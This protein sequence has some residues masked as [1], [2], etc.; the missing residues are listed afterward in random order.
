MN[1]EVLYIDNE[2]DIT[3]VINKVK[4][5]KEKIVALVPPKN[6]GV[7]RS[8]VNLRL[9]ARTADQA[10][11]RVV[12]ISNNTALKTMAA[13]AKI[14]V[15]KTLQSKPEIPEI[16]ALEID[17]E[18][19]IDGEKLPVAAFMKKKP[20]KEDD[21]LSNLDIDDNKAFS[22]KEPASTKKK[23]KSG[24]KLPNFSDFRKKMFL[25]GGGALILIGFLVWAIWFAPAAT[26]VINA[27]TAV[28]NVRSKVDL[29]TNEELAKPEDGVLFSKVE[30]IKKE[31]EVSFDAT[32]EKEIGEKAKGTITLSQNTESDGVTVRSGTGFSS[33]DCTFVTTSNVVIPG[34]SNFSGGQARNPG[35]IEVAVQALD[36]GEQCNLSA[37]NYLSPID[38]VAARGGVMA[39]GSKKTVKVV[40]E[41]DVQT[42]KQKMAD[43]KDENVKSELVSK[44]GDSYKIIDDS[45]KAE[46][47]EATI[48]PKVG[49]EAENGKA[50]IK[51]DATYTLMAIDKKQLT[52]FVENEMKGQSDKPE[53][54]KVYQ[55]GVDSAAFS[56]FVSG[57]GA[58]SLV[59]TT[60]GKTGPNIDEQKIKDESK[61]KRYGEVQSQIEAINGVKD[62]DVKFSFFWV[63]SVPDNDKKIKIE[64]TV[65]E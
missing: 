57:D 14:P 11:K 21:L 12:L 6:T 40:T 36:V 7:L 42:A 56:D 59:V 22:K 18:D 19:V 61:K 27:Q 1:K 34:A 49:D 32:G 16:D 2:D 15:A 46:Y 31:S 54:Q 52:S 30:T 41:Q 24:K 60:S 37:R 55:N 45:Y 8:A 26:I 33:G 5:A 29:T 25:I 38:I 9:L 4:Q 65:D 63:R 10:D 35:T 17:G 23:G 28:A 47:A 44:F 64:F 3:D 13:T 20:S 58:T 53:E 62:V 51:S 48:S 39:G 50:S 43:Q